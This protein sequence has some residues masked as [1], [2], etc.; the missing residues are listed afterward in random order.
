MGPGRTLSAAFSVLLLVGALSPIPV[1]AQSSAPTAPTDLEASGVAD[2]GLIVLSWQDN[3]NDEDSYLVE[4]STEGDSG[5]WAVIATLPADTTEYSDFSLA[6]G[7]T[8]WYR[9]AAVNAA[10]SSGYSNVVSG[11]ASLFPVAETFEPTST[12]L[13]PTPTPS[14]PATGGGAEPSGPVFPWIVAGVGA[15]FLLAGA[16]RYIARRR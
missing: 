12:P 3:A 6:N 5:P 1:A 11:T 14:L 10:G 15:L 2:A 16:G 13:A 4:R 7:I 9:V 8:Y